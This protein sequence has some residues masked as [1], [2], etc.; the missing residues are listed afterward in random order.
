M[1]PSFEGVYTLPEGI[2][3]IAGGAFAYCSKLNSLTIP[4]SVMNIGS[5]TFS[6]CTSLTTIICEAT[7]PP[8]LGSGNTLSNVT[9]VYVPIES[10][11]AY[12]S[13][14]NWSYYASK[15]QASYIP[16]TCS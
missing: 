11:E 6:S 3:Q 2:E 12:K 13:A 9:I 15:I 5:S 1:P 10:V 14:T 16:Q 4:N 8:T 7:T